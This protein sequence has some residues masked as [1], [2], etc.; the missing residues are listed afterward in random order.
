MKISYRWL[1]RYL[2]IDLNPELVSELLTD[3]GLEVE[4]LEE[5]E[6][7]PGGLRGVVV[8]EVLTCEQHPNADRLRITT[9]N[10]G[11]EEALQIVCGAPNVA[12][13]QKV[14]VATVGTTLYPGGEELKIKKGKIRGEV[15]M[16]M[17]CAQDE[18]G[19]GDDHDGILVLDDALH[20]GTPCSTVFDIESDFV[21]EIGLTPNRTDAMGHI[22]VARDLRAA[23]L[24][25]GMGAP[26]LEIPEAFYT[27]EAENPISLQIEDENGCSSYRGT[28][29]SNATI[30][31]SP[32]WLKEHLVAIGLAP[33]NNAVDITNFVLHT[34]G[35]PL[36]AFDADTIAGNTVR[37][38]QAN[39]DEK[40]TTLDEVERTLDVQDCI[41]ADATK[42]MCIAGVLGGSTSAVTTSTK[43]IYLEGAY[44][45]SVR[46]R[47]TAKRHGINSDA[48]YRYERGVDP[49][50]T[51]AAHAYAV[52][53]L[54]E[55]TGGTASAPDHKGQ[56]NFERAGIEFSRMKVMKLI[57]LELDQAKMTQILELLDFEITKIEG[58][59]W[60]VLVP[61]YR[62]DVTRDVDVAEELLR[63]YGFNEVPV[64][65]QMRISVAAHDPRPEKI[66]RSVLDQLTGNG[67][68]EI[69]NNSLGKGAHYTDLLPEVSTSLIEMLNPLSL[70]L[71]VMR[72]NLLFGGLQAISFNQKRQQSNLRFFERGKI[73]G[74]GANGYYENAQLDLFAAGAQGEDYWNSP[75]Q[76]NDYFWMKGLLEGLFRRLGL[77]ISFTP[78]QHSVYGEYVILK[79]GKN[80]LGHLGTV[81]PKVSK[82]F[83]IKT[84]V[85]H[86]SINWESCKNVLLQSNVS[87]F[88]NLPKFPSVRRD[89]ALLVDRSEHYQAIA[90]CILQV[91]K[92]LLVNAFLFDVYEGD[93]LPADKKSYAI[94]MIFQDANKTL[95]D[96]AVD[97]TVNRILDQLNKRTGAVLRQ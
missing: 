26:E 37:I 9:V 24:T 12:A 53:L 45:D 77:P 10:V 61:T 20:P 82:H 65:N 33:K 48:S 49:N 6:T 69:M 62:V 41:I 2:P 19:L 68:F 70:D 15:S 64:P 13:G 86:A 36:H 92:G 38:R 11:T 5:V 60:N 93:K 73:Y 56:K 40:L 90:D 72:N 59:V 46:V 88:K 57:G 27:E 17:I 25:K 44:F 85:I 66:E 94:G 58:D 97:K 87:L 74:Q 95:N 31:E 43:N 16:G 89:I 71:N 55:L 54:C 47:K 75:E 84:E 35:H 8:G 96:K 34:F 29:I 4:G 78:A 83:D 3:T 79:S 39:A 22:G 50:A 76:Q 21:F 1:K 32:D 52:A 23:M 51:G 7:I 18:L 81:H 67:F 80:N 91:G 28:Y 14:P 30:K 42:P 63:I